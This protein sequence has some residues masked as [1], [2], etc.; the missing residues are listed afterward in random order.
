MTKVTDLI[1]T[2]WLAVLSFLSPIK[3]DF[4][5]LLT[6]FGAN[7]FVGLLTALIVERGRFEFK[8]A[9]RCVVEAM[10]FFGLVAFIFVIGHYKNAEEMA[11]SCVSFITYSVFYFYTVNIIRNL[12][13]FGRKGSPFTRCLNA[14][15]SLLTAEFVKNLPFLA[16]YAKD[17]DSDTD[18]TNTNDKQKEE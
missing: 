1:V 2:I 6:L 12:R 11:L 14:L 8:K 3:G 5:V 15:Y 17:D 16:K 9:W 18:P 7:F 10:V 4:I 13:Q